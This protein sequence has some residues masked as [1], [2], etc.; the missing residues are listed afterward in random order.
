MEE[1]LKRTPATVVAVCKL[2][3]IWGR[4]RVGVSKEGKSSN[5]LLYFINRLETISIIG[6]ICSMVHETSPV[7]FQNNEV[8]AI[9]RVTLVAVGQ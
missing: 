6:N 5:V 2:N 4:K 7:S 9:V 1:L 8:Y 3:L